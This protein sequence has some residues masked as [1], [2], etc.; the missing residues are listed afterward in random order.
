MP[1]QAY[2]DWIAKGSPF[3]LA[4]PCRDLQKLLQGAGYT[5]YA[6]PNNDHLFAE[7]PEDHTPF[8]AT[9][10]PGTNA[11]G[12]GHAIDI[13]PHSGL[14]SIDALARNIIAAKH[15]NV[16]GTQW[17]KYINWTD[18]NGK[19]HHISWQPTE[20]TRDSADAGHI[21]ISCRSDYTR[22]GIVLMS[23][24]NPLEDNAMTISWD[25]DVIPA[26]ANAADHD[27]NPFWTVKTAIA[28]ALYN[29]RLAS[30]ASR[31]NEDRL[32]ELLARP[33]NTVTGDEL[34]AAF[35]AA[36]LANPSAVDAIATAVASRVGMIP[37]ARE[38]AAAIGGLDW[39]GTAGN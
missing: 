30:N 9:G 35:T 7:P 3:T 6:Y 31:A 23:G 21:H 29:A 36:F 12:Y 1:S 10:W 17:I 32:K 33:A 24:W 20:V 38:I 25:D 5:V 2:Y 28:N 14:M 22:S 15:A 11:F 8:S 26:P 27:T 16:V 39:H 4:L 13:M 34:V 37:T 18:A 19:A